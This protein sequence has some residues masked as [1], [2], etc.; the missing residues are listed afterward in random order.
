[1]ISKTDLIRIYGSQQMQHR[2]SFQYMQNI[3]IDC[4][5]NQGQFPKISEDSNPTQFSDHNK[6]KLEMNSNNNKY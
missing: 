3:K 2:P 4:M 5:L 1:M 6:N